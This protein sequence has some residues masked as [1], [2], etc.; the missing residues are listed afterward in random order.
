VRLE[1]LYCCTCEMKTQGTTMQKSS[2]PPP[3][4]GFTGG[5]QG[6]SKASSQSSTAA[7]WIRREW[8]NTDGKPHRTTG[9]AMENW[10]V[11]PGEGRRVL[12][13]Q[14][15]YLNGKPHR[16]GRPARCSWHVAD[17]GTRILTREEWYRHDMLHLVGGL[18][19][20]W[21][22]TF[23]RLILLRS[24]KRE[25]KCTHCGLSWVHTPRPVPIKL[26]G[27]LKN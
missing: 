6:C 9:P 25:N 23:L 24:R 16:E 19:M 12:S 14:V 26:A 8:D 4:K 1:V 11:L 7:G 15:W 22:N 5:C 18:V 17:N 3:T 21:C 20:R 2:L 13:Y 27:G 10:T